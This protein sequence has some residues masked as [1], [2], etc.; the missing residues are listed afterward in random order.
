MGSKGG[1]NKEGM[2]GVV[3]YGL[4]LGR[5]GRSER[6]TFC[7]IILKM[8]F[9]VRITLYILF[10]STPDVRKERGLSLVCLRP[11]AGHRIL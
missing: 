4:N 7:V 10:S 2:K 3:R 11:K 1:G 9:A 5:V 8:D 6:G